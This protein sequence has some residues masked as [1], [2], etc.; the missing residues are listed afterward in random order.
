MLQ[1]HCNVVAFYLLHLCCPSLYLTCMSTVKS[2]VFSIGT[3]GFFPI[4][5]SCECKEEKKWLYSYMKFLKFF[6][7]I[8]AYFFF[9]FSCVC[10]I[11]FF[12]LMTA[13]HNMCQRKN[14]CDWAVSICMYVVVDGC[15]RFFFYIIIMRHDTQKK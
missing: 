15:C 7:I 1:Q 4:I 13:R 2:H 5:L 14:A 3:S 11:K 9:V 6:R 12:R 10:C 8:S